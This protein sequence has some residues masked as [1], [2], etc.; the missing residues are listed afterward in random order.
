M[1]FRTPT[2]SALRQR[3]LD[4][5]RMRKLQPRTQA[6]YI[7]AVRRLASFLERAPDTAT[8]EDLRSAHRLH[9]DSSHHPTQRGPADHSYSRVGVVA[10]GLSR[11]NP[12]LRRRVATS[13]R[14]NAA[15]PHTSSAVQ[16]R[17][18]LA[19]ARYEHDS[20]AQ[21]PIAS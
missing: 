8:A 19:H 1:E 17:I 18:R 21:I 7:R 15:A 6:G 20:A 11:P 4:D 10:L 12:A 13:A 14:A 5:M 9:H 3:M 16:P 2:V